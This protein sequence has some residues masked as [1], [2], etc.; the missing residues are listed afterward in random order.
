MVRHILEMGALHRDLVSLTVRFELTP[1]VA[2]SRRV[3]VE[4]VF[5]RFWHVTTQW[6][7][8]EMPDLTV[9]MA[10]AHDHGCD[11]DFE[12]AVFFGTHDDV[13]ASRKQRL[14]PRWRRVLFALM[15]RNAARTVDRFHLPGAR[16]V[17]V[18]R[19]IEL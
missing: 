4:Q 1:R 12:R 14:L 10:C 2:T 7:F 16:F 11:V 15:Y 9:A 19:Q 17:E 18:G 8:M 3:V 5:D 6:G 13:V